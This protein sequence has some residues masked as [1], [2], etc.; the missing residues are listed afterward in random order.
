M[1]LY[2]Q[3]MFNAIQSNITYRFS[4][5]A[6]TLNRLLSMIV[7]ISVWIAL[8]NGADLMNHTIQQATLS[9]MIIYI[10]ITTLIGILIQ[11]S[12]IYIISEKISSGSIVMNLIRPIGLFKTIMFETIGAKLLTVILE[13]IPILTVGVFLFNVSLPI[14]WSTLFFSLSIFNGF[15]I[16]FLL[17]YL[18]GL[19]SFWYYR[20][21]HLDFILTQVLN[22]F[23][24]L[25]V[26]IWFFPHTLKVVSSFLPFELIYYHPLVIFLEKGNIYE[27]SWALMKGYMWIVI[28]SILISY[29]WSKA[30]KKLVI[31]GG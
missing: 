15:I 17:T 31:Q 1:K 22:F 21:F 3:I 2:W 10:L 11:N 7:Y 27:Y 4:T 24:G 19:C 13:F 28:L 5:L 20:I 8:Y 18:L 16:Y 25:L 9:E 6:N 30:M 14:G 29:V 12:N 26:P 23:S